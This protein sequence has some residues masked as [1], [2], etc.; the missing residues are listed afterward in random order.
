MRKQAGFL[1]HQCAHR[2]KIL[3]SRLVAEPSQRGAHFRKRQFGLVAQTEKGFGASQLL[4]L[5]NYGEYSIGSHG[6]RAGF[7][8]IAAKR[9]VTAIIAAKISQR[10]EY[11]SRISDDL[12]FEPLLGSDRSRKQVG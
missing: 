8:R 4:G 5:A 12:G 9:A 3:Q 2:L 1:K 6:M 11:F 10:N 7:I